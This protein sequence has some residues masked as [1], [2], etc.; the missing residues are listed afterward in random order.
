MEAAMAPAMG[1]GT[2]ESALK[3]APVLELPNNISFVL[4]KDEATAGAEKL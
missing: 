2:R 3:T 4:S 1:L